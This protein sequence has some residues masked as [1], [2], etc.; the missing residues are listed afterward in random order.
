[1]EFRL[2]GPLEVRGAPEA[3]EPPAG[4]ERA[5]LAILLLRANQPVSGDELVNELWGESPPTRPEKNLQSY[6]SR[7]RRR[8]GDDRIATTPAGY[9]IRVEQGELDTEQFERLA[10][11]GASKLVAGEIAGAQDILTEALALWRGPALADFRFDSFAQNETRRLESLRDAAIADR[12]DAV[13]ARAPG[14]VIPELEALI[15]SKPLWERPRAQLMLALY[16][17]GRQSEALNL[18][19]DTRTL[20]AEEL[21]IE[22]SRELQE[23]QHAILNQDPALV[24]PSLPADARAGKRRRHRGLIAV[25]A[26]A[27]IVIVAG[28]AALTLDSGTTPQ[29]AVKPDSVA[30]LDAATGRVTAQAP[31]IGAPS[32]LALVGGKV[33][34][35]GEDSH[36][37]SELDSSTLALRRQLAPGGFADELTSGRGGLWMLDAVARRLIE[38][39]P[40]YAGVKN[41][42]SL[43]APQGQAQVGALQPRP[44]EVLTAVRVAFTARDAWVTDGGTD[45]DEIDISGLKPR[46]VRQIDLGAPL[47]GI[48]AGEGAVWALSGANATVFELDPATGRQRPRILLESKPGLATPFGVGI[49]AGL[50][51]VWVLEGNAPAV[52]R[53]DPGDGSVT[54]TIQLPI[55]SEPTAIAAGAGAVW[56]ADSGDGLVSRID[57]SSNSA[58]SIHVGGAPMTVAAAGRTV[59]VGVQTGIGNASVAPAATLSPA[60]AA[61]LGALPTSFCSPVY[62]DGRHLPRLL[63]AADLPLQGAG[64]YQETLQMSDAVR[65]ELARAGYRA[66]AYPVGYQLCDDSSAQYDAW[67]PA[68][69]TR[70]ARAYAAATHVVGILGP[71]NSGCAEQEIPIAEASRTGPLPLISSAATY[72]GLT[73]SGPGTSRGEPGIYYPRHV[74]NFVRVVANDLAQGT[75]DGLVARKLGVRSL[76]LLEDGNPYGIGLAASVGAE[77][78]RL[79]ITIAGTSSW[80][81]SEAG[82]RALARRIKSSGAD[83]VFISGTFDESGGSVMVAL[84]DALGP[85]E[86]IITPDGF[87]PISLLLRVG[88]AA[89]GVT[90][91]I[92]ETDPAQL[93]GAGAVFTSGFGA[94]VGSAVQ[95]YSASAAQAT[96]TLLAAIARSNG[97][98]AS[99]NARLRAEQTTGGILGTFHFDANGDTTAGIVT[100]Y[101]VENGRAVVW[102]VL[103]P[104]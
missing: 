58:T 9:V 29:V 46:L 41:R 42:T 28:V 73:R 95:P 51:S 1:M 11:E 21:G 47:N 12:I 14:R 63:I 35:W 13:L 56:V 10:G 101:R 3:Y 2:L 30:L 75:A 20:L 31:V 64:N 74:R 97:T 22:P 91:S 62:Y 40:A 77:A 87:T 66:G 102:E 53:I 61:T 23:L 100:V 45:V 68:T 44:G 104:N 32:Q 78:R 54:E 93:T 33:W 72:V 69:C 55:D 27:L 4:K 50:G 8:L 15:A 18:Y 71:F 79:G 38:V 76:Y 70:N 80:S 17:T 88:P 65:Y 37:L 99:V 5:V 86:K 34:V 26:G 24:P 48:A 60:E 92:A 84:R 82:Q 94:A 85:G 39:D 49:V 25:A 90:V 103:T 52:T 43:P 96:D 89:E 98:R 59:V 67:S 36:A 81:S 7:L 6:I 83:G 16:R 19:R 57:A